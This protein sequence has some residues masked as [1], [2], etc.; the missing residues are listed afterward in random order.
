VNETVEKGRHWSG[1]GDIIGIL[2]GGPRGFD[3]TPRIN[4]DLPRVKAWQP[5]MKVS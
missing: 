3:K 2:E 1:L 5:R 4:V